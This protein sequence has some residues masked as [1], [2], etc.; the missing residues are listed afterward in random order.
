MPGFWGETSKFIEMENEY[1]NTKELIEY[2]KQNPHPYLKTPCI[3][4]IRRWA[5]NGKIPTMPREKTSGKPLIFKKSDIDEW[6]KNNRIV[7]NG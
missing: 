7:N 1:M 5:R 2:L 4:I 3:E 6:N